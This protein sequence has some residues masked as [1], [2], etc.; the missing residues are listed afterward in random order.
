MRE[1]EITKTE[2][3]RRQID[4]AILMLFRN[5]DPL[6]VHTVAMAVFRLLRDLAKSRGLKDPFDS[7]IPPGTERDFWGEFNH[8]ANFLKHADQ[9]PNGALSPFPEDT[10]DQLLV[11]ACTYF[12]LLGNR[13]TL[14]MGVLVFWYIS[15]H[16]ESLL[17]SVGP[18]GVGLLDG[19]SDIRALPRS[20]QLASGL[21]R[22]QWAQE[23]P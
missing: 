8:A 13:W 7:M 17:K 18:A 1:K 6:A 4:A 2:A 19:E 12:E 23:Q 20:E 10:N 11:I 15:L 14:E 21:M 16:P 9:D 22:L 3:A 5:D